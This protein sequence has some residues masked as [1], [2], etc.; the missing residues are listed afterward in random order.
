[1]KPW[2]SVALFMLREGFKGEESKWKYYFDVLPESTNSTIYCAGQKRSFVRLRCCRNQTIEHY[3]RFRRSACAFDTMIVDATCSISYYESEWHRRI[4]DSD[5]V[6]S[7][8]KPIKK[9]L[10]RA[11]LK[12][13]PLKNLNVMLKLN[14]LGGF[15][16]LDTGGGPIMGD[17]WA[18]KGLIKE[19]TSF[20]LYFNILHIHL[21]DCK[22]DDTWSPKSVQSSK[23]VQWFSE[24]EPKA[25]EDF[26]S[27]R[28]NDLLSLI[29]SGDKDKNQVKLGMP[30][31]ADGL[32]GQ[33]SINNK[34]DAAP[35]VL[36]CEDLEQTILSEYG[37]K[38]TNVEPALKNWSA[39]GGSTAQPSAHVDNN[40]SF[41]LL[42]MLHKST[43]QSNSTGQLVFREHGRATYKE[44]GKKNHI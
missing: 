15:W 1:M 2:I 21:R 43:D 7:V 9:D 29:V 23:F 20:P 5:E 31:S 37:S 6:Q 17:L 19:G 16:V 34:E 41:H 44:S 24:E 10:K 26:T 11:P 22:P 33:A 14:P 28:Q 4:I 13:N 27:A 3:I 35:T 36:T 42:S 38:P 12:K 39:G 30:P 32:S 18:L 8:V 40:A 25:I